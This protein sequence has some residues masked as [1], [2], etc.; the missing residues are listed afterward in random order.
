MGYAGGEV[1]KRQ[2]GSGSGGGEGKKEGGCREGAKHKRDN[3]DDKDDQT[4]KISKH[5]STP[6]KRQT[7][8]VQQDS[9]L[10][11]HPHPSV[12]LTPDDKIKKP[13]SKGS[14][15]KVKKAGPE[16]I[17]EPVC[18]ES[19]RGARYYSCPYKPCEWTTVSTEGM[20]SHIK[21]VHALFSYSC[22]YCHFTTKNFD[23][24][25]AHEKGCK[26]EYESD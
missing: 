23:S 24:L 25:K 10:A 2:R 1:G 22:K 16:G 8:H 6:Q 14:K 4:Q 17:L 7:A 5:K 11:T 20:R 9:S 21:Q 26:G 15:R 13:C 12:D 3:T 18:Q 19:T